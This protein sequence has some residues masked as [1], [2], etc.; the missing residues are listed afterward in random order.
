[1]KFTF[2]R[3]TNLYS[4]PA[5]AV[6]DLPD[7]SKIIFLVYATGKKHSPQR[8]HS[9]NLIRFIIKQTK[10]L[11][12]KNYYLLLFIPLWISLCLA[13]C[14]KDEDPRLIAAAEEVGEVIDV[15]EL[16]EEGSYSLTLANES[17]RLTIENIED[18]VNVSCML[19]YFPDGIPETFRTYVTL[20]ME[21]EVPQT[22]KVQS[23]QCGTLSYLKG[24]SNIEDVKQ[25]IATK[26]RPQKEEYMQAFSSTFDRGAIFS[27]GENIYKLYLAK[28]DPHLYD[29]EDPYAP[30][31]YKF[32]FILTKIE[33]AI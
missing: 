31:H 15:F 6:Q 27:I 12:K 20:K 22:V 13:G 30:L 10:H 24:R 23:T 26:Q 8:N 1:M 19:A 28:A 29:V 32:I 2:V 33:N 16:K 5:E 9:E 25:I 3:P 11:M 14:N 21:G 18:N 7:E 17:Y 4:L